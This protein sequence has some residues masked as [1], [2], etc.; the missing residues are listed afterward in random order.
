VAW[1]AVGTD[2]KNPIT[3]Q[4]HPEFGNGFPYLRW[5]DVGLDNYWIRANKHEVPQCG[6]KKKEFQ[7]LTWNDKKW[8]GHVPNTFNNF[9]E[10]P[11]EEEID[12]YPWFNIHNITFDECS[13]I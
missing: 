9:I 11:T 3:Y 10:G 12:W 6:S 7:S 8:R 1:L 4:G 5:N 2:I 13:I